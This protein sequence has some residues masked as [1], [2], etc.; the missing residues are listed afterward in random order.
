M[1]IFSDEMLSREILFQFWLINIM[2]LT[3]LHVRIE[4]DIPRLDL[5][6]CAVEVFLLELDELRYFSLAL[7]INLVD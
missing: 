3:L 6:G 1:K 5:D 2:F 7:V 4:S